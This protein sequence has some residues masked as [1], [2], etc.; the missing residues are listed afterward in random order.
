[1]K[2][3]T[4]TLSV[5]L[6]GALAYAGYLQSE[7]SRLKAASE[8][9]EAEPPQTVAKADLGEEAEPD[10]ALS[11]AAGRTGTVEAPVEAEGAP[12][13]E[14]RE[15]RRAER[16][17]QMLSAFED[18]EMRVDM[19]E[20]QM[21]RVDARYADFFKSLDLSPDELDTLRTLM[22]EE[23]V[24][25]WEM[26]MRTF[27]ADSEEAR[28]EAEQARELQR[29]LIRDQIAALLGEDNAAA[30][31]D[32]SETLPYRGEVE[33]LASSLSFTDSPLSE[34]QS[35][36]LVVAIRD[37]SKS[38]E[39]SVDLSELRGREA[40]NLKSSDIETFFNER[41]ERDE[42]VLQAASESLN[43]AQLAAYAERQLAERERD[44]RQ[45]EFMLQNP[46]SFDRGGPRGG[47]QRGGGQRGGGSR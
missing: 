30:L 16:L 7:L 20:R 1:M 25:G 18:P 12:P 40:A 36:A 2:S 15:A 35:E 41:A 19:I 47:G 21:N 13:R 5:L 33:S 10:V 14:S 23:G 38:Y 6:A 39:Y 34:G 32:Y 37:V 8:L 42:L 24:V 29:E 45:M 27:G 4:I 28:A 9:G 46:G 44:R 43:D 17:K 11:A 22:A 3:S 26:R 31:Q